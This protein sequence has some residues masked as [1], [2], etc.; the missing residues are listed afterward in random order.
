MQWVDGAYRYCG[1]ET[2]EVEARKWVRKRSNA[3]Y[4]TID[5]V[6]K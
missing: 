5:K 3:I 6:N 2:S 4:Y 1:S